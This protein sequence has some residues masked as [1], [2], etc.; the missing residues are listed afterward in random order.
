M[1]ICNLEFRLKSLNFIDHWLDRVK[2]R[3]G[4][5]KGT[6]KPFWNFSE[7]ASVANKKERRQRKLKMQAQS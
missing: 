2:S 6:K 4:R 7:K 1:D 3:R 5:P